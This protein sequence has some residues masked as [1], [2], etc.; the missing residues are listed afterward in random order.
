MHTAFKLVLQEGGCYRCA[1]RFLGERTASA[2]ACP[3]NGNLSRYLT[4]TSSPC[5]VCLGL[6]STSQYLQKCVESIQQ[7]NYEFKDYKLHVSI[8]AALYL[9]QEW[10]KGMCSVQGISVPL[11]TDIKEVFKWVFSPDLSE[12]LQRPFNSDSRFHISLNF[13]SKESEQEVK[14]LSSEIPNL[15]VKPPRNKKN[16]PPQI[17]SS[18]L[19]KWLGSTAAEKLVA[20]VPRFNYYSLD[21]EVECSHLP[22]YVGGNYMKYS[23]VVSQSPWTV[24][25][26]VMPETS[27]QDCIG[28]VLKEAYKAQDSILH[29][30]GREDVDVRMLGTGRPFIIELVQ[31]KLE[32]P[33]PIEPLKGDVEVQNLREVGQ[34]AFAELRHGEI[35]KMKVYSC[36]VWVSKAISQ[37][38]IALLNSTKDL[39][40]AQK[41]P[42]RVLHRRP[43]KTRTKWIH[44]IHCK[45]LNKHFIEVRVISSGGTYIKEFVHGDL[46]RTL[47]SIG[48]LLGCKA[49]IIQL[50]VLG[51]GSD[52]KELV[53][54]LSQETL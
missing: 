42:L 34:E 18:A 13:C 25:G 33:K 40:L 21:L 11:V 51:L 9:R 20:L 31:P 19:N 3:T 47:P 8:P 38:D 15:M 7:S 6:L 12:K 54:I 24:E 28:N 16:L 35:E 37:E 45:Q 29:A 36:V 1:L 39:E 46:G 32:T 17:S 22:I 10:L 50:D 48:S 27:V 49:D 2:Y 4:E 44:K 41:T 5:V 43:L 30:A 26:E 23:R 14:N 52:I 53:H